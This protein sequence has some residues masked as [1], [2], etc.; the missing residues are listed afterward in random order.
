MVVFISIRPLIR[1]GQPSSIMLLLNNTNT[2]RNRSVRS[3]ESKMACLR[4]NHRTLFTLCRHESPLPEK[5]PQDSQTLNNKPRG[6][7]L[8]LT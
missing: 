7:I 8:Y 3:R 2:I 4:D 6:E 5:L 1:A